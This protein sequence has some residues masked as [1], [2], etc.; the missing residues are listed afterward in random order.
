MYF[1][2]IGCHH[3]RLQL[4]KVAGRGTKYLFEIYVLP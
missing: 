4:T 2:I 3:H 1:N